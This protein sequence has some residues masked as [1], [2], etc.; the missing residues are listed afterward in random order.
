MGIDHA[1]AVPGHDVVTNQVL[2]ELALALSG[3]TNNVGVVLA[4]FGWQE[5]SSSSSITDE[6]IS[7]VHDCY[8][9]TR[10]SFGVLSKVDTS[11][12]C[13]GRTG[14]QQHVVG[15]PLLAQARR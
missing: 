14:E 15:V 5:Y 7:R 4:I 8:L 12:L 6:K 13:V 2:H 9:L 11:S 1:Q 3:R 10:V